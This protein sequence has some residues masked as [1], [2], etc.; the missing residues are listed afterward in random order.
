MIKINIIH[1]CMDYIIFPFSYYS[2]FLLS[3]LNRDV[4][5][6]RFARSSAWVLNARRLNGKNFLSGAGNRAGAVITRSGWS[7]VGKMALKNTKLGLRMWVRAP[8]VITSWSNF[9]DNFTRRSLIILTLIHRT[10]F[11]GGPLSYTFFLHLRKLRLYFNNF[12]VRAS[13]KLCLIDGLQT[14]IYRMMDI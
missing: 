2:E 10:S 14:I 6:T 3:F 8:I 1:N 13:S 12:L 4:F 5:S 7:M 11:W 9:T